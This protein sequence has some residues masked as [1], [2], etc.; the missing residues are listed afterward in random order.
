MT[1]A[2]GPARLSPLSTTQAVLRPNPSA[3]ACLAIVSNPP[4]IK[5]ARI[6][7][8]FAACLA[9]A[10][11]FLMPLRMGHPAHRFVLLLVLASVGRGLCYLI[12]RASFL[13]GFF[14]CIPVKNVTNAG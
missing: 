3:A 14:S 5:A 11:R 8:S 7:A 2:E 1:L 4:A 13:P 9:F 6:S 10:P 12:L